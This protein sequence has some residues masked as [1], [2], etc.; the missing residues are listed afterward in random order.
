MI[1]CTK[2]LC[3]TATVSAIVKYGRDSRNLPPH[4]LQFSSDATP[5]VV[6]NSTNRCNLSCRHCYIDAHDRT[7]GRMPANC[8]LRKR[9]ILL[10]DLAQMKVP[11]LLFSGGEPLVRPDLF[12]LGAYAQKQYPATFGARTRLATLPT[13]RREKGDYNPEQIC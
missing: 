7:T 5:I 1:G 8:L 11:V 4:M 2:L 3:G 10:N 12:E 9:N 13:G 6:W